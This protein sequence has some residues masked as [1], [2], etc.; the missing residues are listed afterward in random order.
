MHE[1]DV[2]VVFLFET[3]LIV[4]LFFISPRATS[5]TLQGTS[6]QS[7]FEHRVMEVPSGT[8]SI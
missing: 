8:R 2:R 3:G 1:V 6:N 4:L 5:V 7:R